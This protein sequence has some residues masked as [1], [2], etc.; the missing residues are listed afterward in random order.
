MN[1]E[2]IIEVAKKRLCSA[3][4]PGW[5]F[6]SENPLF[7]AMAEAVGVT[8]VGPNPT[9]MRKMADKAMA[10][11]TMRELGLSPIPGVD[12]FLLTVEQ[13]K[14][15][16]SIV[17]FPLLLKAVAGGGGKG[18][19]K[20]FSPE[21]LEDAFLAATAEAQSAFGNGAMYME[22]LII[23]GRHIDFSTLRW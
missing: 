15:A 19:R 1:K 14:Q 16:S 4:H 21:D 8:F 2:K 17:G 9:S 20:V 10:R 12:D 13:A 11:S 23:G 3:I 6:L 22:R 18:M 7:A 5:G